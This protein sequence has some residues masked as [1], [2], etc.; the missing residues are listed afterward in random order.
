NR[1]PRQ[2]TPGEEGEEKT[3]EL[4][5]KI[6]ADVG[7]LGMPNAGKSTFIRAVSSAKPKVADYPF[8]T[9]HPNLGM[10]RIDE[11]NSFVVADI[12]GLIEGAAHGAGIGYQFLKHLSRN[13]LLLH[14]IDIAPLDEYTNPEEDAVAIVKELQKFD[15]QLFEKPRWI[16]FN[17]IDSADT[18]KIHSIQNNII[19]RLKKEKLIPENFNQTRTEVFSISAVTKE[20]I[21]PLL[22]TIQDYLK[23]LKI[24]SNSENDELAPKNNQKNTHYSAR[25]YFS[26]II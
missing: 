3:L 15:Q 22:Y 4:E 11:N 8:T 20:G 19:S 13:H 7:L 9:L 12:P 25:R 10:V 6:M 26:K 1:T 14:I 24:N 18:E 21:E 17:K 16:V 23:V 5:L 2:F